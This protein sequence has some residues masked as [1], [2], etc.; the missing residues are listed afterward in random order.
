MVERQRIAGLHGQGV[1]VGEIARHLDRSAWTVSHEL[2]RN[3]LAHDQ[4]ICDALLAHARARARG[5][6]PGRS[7]LAQDGELL[8]HLPEGHR[9]EQLVE[10]LSQ[11][12][13]SEMARH[14]LVADLF[15]PGVSF[16]NPG[17]PWM[18]GTN[19]D[20]NGL[21]RQYLPKAADLRVHTAGDLAVI[22]TKLN[23]RPRQTLD[24]QT[25]A[26]IFTMEP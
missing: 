21:L 11:D 3:T 22:E 8:V 9:A 14:D 16:A 6:R 24:W 1:G 20:T 26:A 23:N 5:A 15:T 12:Q 2:R 17:S 18:R 7:R 10:A 25:P 4:G 13:G 19:E